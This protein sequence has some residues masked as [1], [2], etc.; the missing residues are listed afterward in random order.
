MAGN[1]IIDATDGAI[2]LFWTGFDISY[3]TDRHHFPIVIFGAPGTLVTCNTIVTRN[4]IG[5][6]AINMV[7][8]G[9]RK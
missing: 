5:L 9:P 1:S 7:D 8:Y 6:G 4:R 2:G 3:S